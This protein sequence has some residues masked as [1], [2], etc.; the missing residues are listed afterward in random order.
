[1]AFAQEPEDGADWP[2]NFRERLHQAVADVLRA[3][4]YLSGIGQA[5]GEY[6]L[7]DLVATTDVAD[8][9]D[10]RKLVVREDDATLV[11]LRD[12]A[13]VELGSEDYE[14]TTWYK[15]KPAIFIGVTQ[16]PGANPLTVARRVHAA[17]DEIRAQLAD[18]AAQA[19]TGPAKLDLSVYPGLTRAPL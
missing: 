7:I 12:I 10:F 2:F 14:T 6:T 3:N 17:M 9:E 5:R 13:R 15:G 16:A 8:V 11:R 19:I 4:N 18:I 1:M